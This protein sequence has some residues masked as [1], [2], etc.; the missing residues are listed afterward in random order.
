RAAI[1]DAALTLVRRQGWA[2]TSIDQICRSAR[3]TKGAFFHYFGSKEDLGVAAAERWQDVTSAL[4]VASD[5]FQISD[6]LQR[7]HAYLDLRAKL[8]DGPLEAVTCF[9]GTTVQET[10]A[11]SERIRAACGESIDAHVAMLTRDLEEL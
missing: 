7:I 11:T 5:Y 2:S 9:A 6:P 3:V 10:F 4:F 1:L 8:A